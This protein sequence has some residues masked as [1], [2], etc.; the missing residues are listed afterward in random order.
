MDN[1]QP[2]KFQE[3]I[4]EKKGCSPIIV[5]ILAILALGGIGFGIF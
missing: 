2:Q 1:N 5:V 3:P 4:K